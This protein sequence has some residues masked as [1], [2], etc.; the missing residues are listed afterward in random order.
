MLVHS[1]CTQKFLHNGNKKEEEKDE[2]HKSLSDVGKDCLELIF[3]TF[4]DK[5]ESYKTRRWVIC[6]PRTEEVLTEMLTGSRL[7]SWYSSSPL[8]L[9]TMLH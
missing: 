7:V 1:D 9:R 5:S 4:C 3:V 8:T 6:T 2:T